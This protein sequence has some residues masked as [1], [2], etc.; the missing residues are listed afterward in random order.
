MSDKI[1]TNSGGEDPDTILLRLPDTV[2]MYLCEPHITREVWMAEIIWKMYR[3][4][5]PYVWKKV[6]LYLRKSVNSSLM[7]ICLP[8]TWKSFPHTLDWQI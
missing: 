7:M 1:F 2:M 8:Y 3:N 5:W 6:M 4:V